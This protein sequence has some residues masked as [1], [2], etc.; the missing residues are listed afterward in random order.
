MLELMKRREIVV[1]QAE[2][3]GPIM[4]RR[5]TPEERAAAGVTG[6]DR[7]GPAGRVAGVLRMTGEAVDDDRAA[8]GRARRS[9][10]ADRP[11]RPAPMRRR[12]P[13]GS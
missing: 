9:I 3:C 11:T 8:V 5:T 6:S 1:E 2:P 10:G 13:L 7:G 12:A 4:A